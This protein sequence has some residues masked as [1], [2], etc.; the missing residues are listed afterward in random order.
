M[1]H[2]QDDASGDLAQGYKPLFFVVKPVPLG[3]GERVV[4]NRLG[5]IKAYPVFRKILPVLPLVVLE[6][7]AG[8]DPL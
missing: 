8:P 1:H 2:K 4:E 6:S 3:K 5:H 7:H